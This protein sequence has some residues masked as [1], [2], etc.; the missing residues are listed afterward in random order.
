MSKIVYDTIDECK[1]N[2]INIKHNR[3]SFINLPFKVATSENE[4][5][6][7]IIKDRKIDNINKKNKIK[8]SIFNE[9]VNEKLDLEIY[10]YTNDSFY[11]TLRYIFYNIGIGI[12]VNIKD[13]KVYK[14]VPF[15]NMNFKNNWGHLLNINPL[16]FITKKHSNNK[17]S[18]IYKKKDFIWL[19]KNKWLTNNCLIGHLKEENGYPIGDSRMGI[20]KNLLDEVCKNK[21]INDVEFFINKRDFPIITKDLTEPYF[22]IFDNNNIKLVKHSY[23]NH[24]PILSTCTSDKYADITI[25]TEDDINIWLNKYH[26]NKCNNNYKDIKKIKIQSWKNK[27]PTA[28]FRGSA[29]GCGVT[30]NDNQ[31]LKLAHISKLWKTDNK[32]NEN[33]SIDNTSFL[34]FG[35]TTWN[36]REKK[37][38]NKELTY[39]KPNE[40]IFKL[41]NKLTR[42]EQMSYKYQILVDGHVSAYRL[43]WLM[44]FKS[45]ILY[46]DSEYGWKIWFQKLLV[47]Y[48]HYIPIKKDLSDLAEK[49]EWCKKNDNKCKIIGENSYNF[50]KKYLKD[51]KIL[52]YMEYLLN[53]I[54]LKQ[55]KQEIYKFIKPFNYK[56]NTKKYNLSIIVPYRD[57]KLHNRKKQLDIF[58]P[59]MEKFLNKLQDKYKYNIL[60][61]EQSSKIKNFNRGKLLNI[62][63]DIALKNKSDYI[64][65]HDIDLLPDNNLLGYYSM[66]PISPI[67]I[68]YTWKYY[69]YDTYFGGIN[70]INMIDFKLL[71]GF[72][73]IIN[74]TGWG[75]EDDIFYNRLVKINKL[76]ILRPLKGSIKDL[77][78]HNYNNN[79][80]ELYK[81]IKKEKKIIKENDILNWKKDGLS[82]L[83]YKI[84]S[85]KKILNNTIIYSVNF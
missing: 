71:N 64:I 60:I 83:K 65:L 30:I 46:I 5:N 29:T 80:K 4:L 1:Q 66:Y 21:K 72:S 47:P 23:N 27:I 12:Y 33:N 85:Y 54:S 31:R 61:I 8:K 28:I 74:E 41:S 14:F 26:I 6:E 17:K 49:I 73:N 53:N 75:G 3:Y 44:M 35:I 84:L 48:K 62:G 7:L 43:I 2:Q 32:Y 20:Y 59:Y 57:D 58:V 37:I 67:H 36:S 24:I 50:Y 76:Q 68:A 79:N 19:D 69:N 52:D 38:M 11:N 81:K 9:I 18:G 78:N 77:D 39:I 40:F 42:E 55:Q 13:N 25:P 82:N 45:V 56:K 10:N 34:D 15:I 51:E 70:S 22:H 63:Y 16:E